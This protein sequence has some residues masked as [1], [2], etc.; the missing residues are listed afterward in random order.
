MLIDEQILN[1]YFVGVLIGMIVDI[2]AKRGGG[3]YVQH[4]QAWV[5]NL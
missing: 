5:E 4:V 3:G 2:S 1:I